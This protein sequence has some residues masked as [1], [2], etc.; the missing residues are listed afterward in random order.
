MMYGLTRQLFSLL[1]AVSVGLFILMYPETV[2]TLLGLVL[3]SLVRFVRALS[4]VIQARPQ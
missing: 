4:H 3:S 1:I 2:A